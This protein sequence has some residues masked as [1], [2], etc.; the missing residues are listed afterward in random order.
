M[1]G[2]FVDNITFNTINMSALGIGF[3]NIDAILTTLV[4]ITALVYN[5]KKITKKDE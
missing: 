4:L 1:N 5:V 3:A 2:E